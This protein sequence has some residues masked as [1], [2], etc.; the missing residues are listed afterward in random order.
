M[1]SLRPR[2]AIAAF[3]VVALAQTGAAAAQDA[4]P[5]PTKAPIGQECTFAH[6]PFD[7]KSIHLTGAWGAN[8]AGVYYIRQH[9]SDV[10]WN[11]M[12]NRLLPPSELGRDWNNVA[13]GKLGSDGVI[14]LD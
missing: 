6:R 4:T 10:A 3:A 9:G 2:L 1:P 7:P 8:D 13:I 5:T 11:G 12:S 14:Q